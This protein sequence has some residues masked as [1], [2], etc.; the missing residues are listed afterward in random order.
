MKKQKLFGI[1]RIPKAR[2]LW[3]A[4]TLVLVGCATAPIGENDLLNFLKDGVT[5]REEVFLALGDPNA[6]YEDSR[7][8]TYRLAQDEA[9][10]ILRKSTREWYGVRV[11][12]VIVFDDH[13][14][15]KRHALVQVRSE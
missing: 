13:G 8:L 11:V 14:T 10:W 1:G 2:W 3:V 7:I 4:L 5:T 6:T 12:L 15:V 9:G